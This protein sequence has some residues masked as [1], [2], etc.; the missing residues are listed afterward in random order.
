VSAFALRE[1]P[2]CGFVSDEGLQRPV[3]RVITN[4]GVSHAVPVAWFTDR[5]A[6]LEREGVAAVDAVRGAYLAWASTCTVVTA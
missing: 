6:R 2:T 4:D 1:C 3:L 5:R